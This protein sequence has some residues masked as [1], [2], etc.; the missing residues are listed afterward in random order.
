MKGALL[1]VLCEYAEEIQCPKHIRTKQPL[2]DLAVSITRVT[3]S[4]YQN[5]ALFKIFKTGELRLMDQRC[6]PTF[7]KGKS[8]PT[9]HEYVRGSMH[10]ADTSS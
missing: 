6:P 5:H 1:W 7:R 4:P 10:A 8:G 3:R 2:S 9:I